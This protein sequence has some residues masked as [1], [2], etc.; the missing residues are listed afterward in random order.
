[1]GIELAKAFIR[2]RGDSSQLP[3]ICSGHVS[4]STPAWP[5]SP[6]SLQGVIGGIMGQ[7]LGLG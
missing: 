4:R 1:M 7:W 5:P 3:V 2:I 6:V